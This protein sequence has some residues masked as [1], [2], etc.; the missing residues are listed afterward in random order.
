M[1]AIVALVV[2]VAAL[3]YAASSVVYNRASAH[4]RKAVRLYALGLPG[5]AGRE[6]RRGRELTRLADRITLGTYGR[7]R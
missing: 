3:D 6:M 2:A 4:F 7:I 1:T 5:Q